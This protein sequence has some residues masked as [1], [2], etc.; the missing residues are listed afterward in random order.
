MISRLWV[1]GYRSFELGIFNNNDKKVEVIKDI[2]EN[3]IKQY[4][5]NGLEWVLSGV[6]LGV[7]QFSVDATSKLK[8]DEY[9]IKHAIMLPFKDFGSNWNE[10]NV[11]QLNNSLNKADYYNFVSSQT[12]QNPSQ[13]KNWQQFMLEHTDG[14]LILYDPEQEQKGKPE[15]DYQAALAYSENHDYPVETITFEDLDEFYREMSDN[16]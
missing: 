4:T 15:Y 1:T 7:E 5:E 10:N 14:M 11:S 6:Q 13:L 12:Y 16:N 3:R 2:L 8:A 9:A